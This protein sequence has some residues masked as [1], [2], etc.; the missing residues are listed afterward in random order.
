MQIIV[1][2]GKDK[3]GLLT[4]QMKEKGLLSA[5]HLDFKLSGPQTRTPEVTKFEKMIRDDYYGC[6]CNKEFRMFRKT[7]E[8]SPCT[9][10]GNLFACRLTTG[11]STKH[12]KIGG[13]AKVCINRVTSMLFLP[14]I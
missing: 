2:L 7:M 12:L 6:C 8:S 9:P 13:Y 1:L 5:D 10:R 11:S 4:L 14:A 3:M